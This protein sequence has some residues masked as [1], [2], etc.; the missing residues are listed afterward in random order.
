MK[1]L[2]VTF[3]WVGSSDLAIPSG[4]KIKGLL[5]LFGAQGSWSPKYMK[6]LDFLVTLAMLK[7]P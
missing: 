4:L 5:L 2:F 3:S 6:L 1:V 7:P